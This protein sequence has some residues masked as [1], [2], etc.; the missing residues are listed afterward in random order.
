MSILDMDCPDNTVKVEVS[1]EYYTYD[2]NCEIKGTALDTV[3]LEDP[4][5][6]DIESECAKDLGIEVD[7]IISVQY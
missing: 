3:V 4:K 1:V 5:T 7:D 2:E 6:S